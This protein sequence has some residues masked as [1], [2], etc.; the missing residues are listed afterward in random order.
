MT[1]DDFSTLYVVD[2]KE[3]TKCIIFNDMQL[4][5]DGDDILRLGL[6]IKRAW[7]NT[8]GYRGHYETTIDGWMSILSGWTTGPWDDPVAQKKQ[9]FNDFASQVMSKKITPA[10]PI[11][12]VIDPTSNVFSMGVSILTAHPKIFHAWIGDDL[13]YDLEDALL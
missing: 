11:A 7:I 8:G 1:S 10:A 6:N 3:I 4:T 9:K 2:D 12:L 13:F 5:D